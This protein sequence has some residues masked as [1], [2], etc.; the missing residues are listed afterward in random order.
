MREG[1]REGWRSQPEPAASLLGCCL[2]QRSDDS[3]VEQPRVKLWDSWTSN[4]SD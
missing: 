2:D 4:F 1:G 3:G